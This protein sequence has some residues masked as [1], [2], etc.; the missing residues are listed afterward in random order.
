MLIALGLVGLGGAYLWH[1]A[2]LPAER[3]DDVLGPATM[4]L[5]LGAALIG[6]AALLGVTALRR[7]GADAELA[8][9]SRGHLV[10]L[11]GLVLYVAAVPLAGFTIAT[12]LFL[13]L[14]ACWGG[15]RVVP[16]GLF[17]LGTVALLY[18]IFEVV[19]RVA[20]PRGFG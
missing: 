18:V 10:V 8:R 6:L 11:L 17:A 16:A 4:P 1:A 9:V 19:F 12:A 2:D 14:G 15:Q 20:L 5:A 13:F 3:A 7:R